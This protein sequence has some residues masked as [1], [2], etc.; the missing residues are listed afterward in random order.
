MSFEKYD[1]QIKF[2][3]NEGRQKEYMNREFSV[4]PRTKEDGLIFSF[5]QDIYELGMECPHSHYLNSFLL[6]D[7]LTRLALP[8]ENP[9]SSIPTISGR[10]IIPF[11]LS[12]HR[13][14]ALSSFD[15]L[16]STPMV[17]AFLAV[18]Q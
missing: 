1:P 17:D 2:D 4:I 5:I 8:C 3:F 10:Q 15:L 18:V 13:N 12:G 11:R 6:Y 16:S 9:K 14:L 7:G